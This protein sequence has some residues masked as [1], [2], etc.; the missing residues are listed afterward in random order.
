MESWSRISSLIGSVENKHKPRLGWPLFCIYQL[1]ETGFFPDLQSGLH[2]LVGLYICLYNVPLSGL[3]DWVP[4]PCWVTAI[5]PWESRFPR[6]LLNP[7]P[8]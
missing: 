7:I 3:P 2:M 5:L 1:V 6:S 4:N 8:G